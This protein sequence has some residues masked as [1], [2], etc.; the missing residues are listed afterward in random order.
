MK[1]LRQ[2][3]GM[4]VV[5]FLIFVISG[6][7]SCKRDNRPADRNMQ[8]LVWV[9]Y[10]GFRMPVLMIGQKESPSILLMIHTGTGNSMTGATGWLTDYPASNKTDDYLLALWNKRYAGYP[11]NPD[12]IDGST[13]KVVQYADDYSMIVEQLNVRFPGKKIIVMGRQKGLDFRH[14]K[15]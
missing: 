14:S 4:P 5:L 12:T 9:T 3:A 6:I 13:V 15:K 11:K 1:S 2:F 10:N 8:E 7:V